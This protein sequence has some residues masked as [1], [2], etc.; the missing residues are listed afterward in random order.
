MRNFGETH[1]DHL[2]TL[3]V[4]GAPGL[5]LLLGSLFFLARLSL[6]RGGDDERK[7]FVRFTAMPLAAG[8]ATMMIAGF[9]LELA[10][11]TMAMLYASAIC[12]AWS[13]SDL[14]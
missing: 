14:D 10:A 9:P 5:L 7:R 8:S 4:S 12:C 3:A 13:A 11:S 2:Q 6:P 1:S